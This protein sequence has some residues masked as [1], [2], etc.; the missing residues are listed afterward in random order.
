LQIQQT[1]HVT[2]GLAKGLDAAALLQIVEEQRKTT[3]V[4]AEEKEIKK[5]SFK[6]P[7]GQTRFISLQQFREGKTVGEI[8]QARNLSPATIE[9]HLALFVLSGE[10]DILELVPEPRLAVISEAVEKT[11]V[12]SLYAIKQK[13]PADFT[14]GEI[15]AV[16]NY[17]Q[18]LQERESATTKS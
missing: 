15:R 5:E 8:A 1:V 16:I 13:L 18:Y 12:P 10:L 9:Q 2:T 11:D 17:R 3:P 7:K 14:F 6:A 4:A